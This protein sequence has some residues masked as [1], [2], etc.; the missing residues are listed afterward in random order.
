[1]N[2]AAVVDAEPSAGTP[3][4]AVTSIAPDHWDTQPHAEGYTPLQDLQL[5]GRGDEAVLFSHGTTTIFSSLDMM[6][7]D[8]VATMSSGSDEEDADVVP[9]FR[10]VAHNALSMLEDDYLRTV[11]RTSFLS[12]AETK[13]QHVL[14]SETEQEPEIVSKV[15]A[16]SKL[17]SPSISDSS[18]HGAP[19]DFADF[20][21]YQPTITSSNKLPE[22]DM[23]AV[24]KAVSAIGTRDG[25]LQTAFQEWEHRQK[26]E[27]ATAPRLHPIIPS[28]PLSA[29]RRQT[30]KAQHAASNLSRSATIAEALRCWNLLKCDSTD[31]ETV[32]RIH[33]VGCDHVE[34]ESEQRLRTLFGPIVRWIAAYA[35]APTHL[36]LDLIGPNVPAGAQDR[37]MMLST[38]SGAG[39]RNA[40]KSAVLRCHCAVY[41][42]WL[43]GTTASSDV[44]DSTS[45]PLPDL[46]IA[47]NAGVWGYREWKKTIR[48]LIQQN[49]SIP[50]AFTAYTI[51]EAEDD[52][53]VI[54]EVI[55]ECHSTGQGDSCSWEPIGNPFASR[56]DR[57]TATAT[58]G[59][60]YRENAA[61]QGWRF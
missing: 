48:Y 14:G 45:P 51:Q 56:Q 36:E 53:E 19:T 17:G 25:K 33:V 57:H 61:W 35:E 24:K 12:A 28:A 34:C 47:F 43:S 58:P 59:R 54:Q 4:A 38:N 44:L 32:L 6:Y 10:D 49:Q 16:E 31:T 18:S 39:R 60:R 13:D 2:D 29:F 1:M 41:E 42:D 30:T 5:M 11:Q 50:F 3:L 20:A 15:T 7:A 27:A 22:I 8:N 26:A 9:N 37:T 46:A 55:K 52:F 40:M 23:D 21:S